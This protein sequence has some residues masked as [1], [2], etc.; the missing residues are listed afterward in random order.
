MEKDHG[1]TDYDVYIMPVKEKVFYTML[2]ALV[3]FAI[4]FVFYHNV[5]ISAF[6]CVF[7]CFYPKIKMGEIIKQ[8]K[9][10]LK[11]QFKDMLYALSSS[12]SAGRSVESALRD[13]LKDLFI[14]YPDRDVSIIREVESMV[15]KV[16]MNETV[17]SALADFARRSHLED[18]ENFVDVF[19]TCKRTGGNIVEVIRNASN[20]INDKIEI[21][22]EMETMLAER[23]FEQKVLNVLPILMVVLLSFSAGDY[24]APV[25]NTFAGRFAM[26]V[27]IVLLTLAY[28]IS[29]KIMDI[30]V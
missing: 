2:A 20:I 29:K 25:F 11:L 13:I 4:A 16:E 1:R 23:K 30:K 24:I 18:V 6:A 28:F 26:T 19:Y 10:N 15:R 9:N 17:E 7:A 27:S 12:L 5:V 21:K 3:I 22:M 8:Q 14:L